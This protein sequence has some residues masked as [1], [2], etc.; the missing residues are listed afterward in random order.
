M[1][2]LQ[3]TRWTRVVIDQISL[4]YK[5]GTHNSFSLSLPCL[6]GTGRQS[7]TTRA[8]HAAAVDRR[9]TVPGSRPIVGN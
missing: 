9:N 6:D 5:H 4:R 2:L 3:E 1:L 8:G 7:V